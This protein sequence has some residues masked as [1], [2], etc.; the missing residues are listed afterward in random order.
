ML[1]EN[2]LKLKIWELKDYL[3]KIPPTKD[4]LEVIKNVNIDISDLEFNL[5]RIDYQSLNI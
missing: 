2:A 5:K 3:E 1:L 4:N